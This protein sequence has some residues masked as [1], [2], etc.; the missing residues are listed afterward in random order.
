MNTSNTTNAKEFD[1]NKPN[2]TNKAEVEVYFGVFFDGT[3]NNKIQ[4]M[5]GKLYRRDE[6]LKSIIE[7]ANKGKIKDYNCLKF[8][9]NKGIISDDPTIYYRDQSGEYNLGEKKINSQ[10]DLDHLFIN[11]GYSPYW[12]DFT[13]STDGNILV[14]GIKRED[15]TS[16]TQNEIL[17]ESQLDLLY[18]GSDD[19]FIEDRMAEQLR[20]DGTAI[21]KGNAEEKKGDVDKTEHFS[22]TSTDKSKNMR[23][24]DDANELAGK[25]R[26]NSKYS[27]TNF[28]SSGQVG[29][30]T[31]VAILEAL[32]DASLTPTTKEKKTKYYSIYVEGSGA[33][34]RFSTA[35][36]AHVDLIGEGVL[37]LGKGT[38]PTGAVAKVRK[39]ARKVSTIVK[40]L[41]TE[42]ISL[43]IHFDIFGFSRGSAS[44]R[45][46]AYLV[47]PHNNN[48]CHLEKNYFYLTSPPHLSIPIPTLMDDYT[49]LGE[50]IWKKT[51]KHK[52][53]KKP[54]TITK[55]IR[56]L[57]IYDTVVSIGVYREPELISLS[58][59]GAVSVIASIADA[60]DLPFDAYRRVRPL[61]K[62]KVEGMEERVTSIFGKSHFHDQNVDDY[63]LHATDQAEEVFHICALDELRA[64]FALTDI[65]SS[66]DGGNG[67]ELFLPGCHTDIGGG[68]Y[69]RDSSK[70]ANIDKFQ[71][72]YNYICESNPYSIQKMKYRRVSVANFK[73]MGWLKDGDVAINN[74]DVI[75]PGTYGRF[76]QNK[77]YSYV[78]GGEDYYG[79]TV[80]RD[81]SKNILSRNNIIMNRYVKPGYSNLGLHLMQKRAN[82]EGEKRKMFN[83]IPPQYDVPSGGPTVIKEVA[84][85]LKRGKRYFVCPND[86]L[87]KELRKEY[88]HFSANEQILSPA[89]NIIVNPPN[90]ISANIKKGVTRDANEIIGDNIK[91]N[92]EVIK[93]P[94]NPIGR[95]LE[96]VKNVLTSSLTPLSVILKLLPQLRV[97]MEPD[98]RISTRIVYKGKKDLPLKDRVKMLYDYE[99][100]ES[101]EII[102]V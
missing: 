48:D 37:G 45:M 96:F 93:R 86:N 10:A 72:P 16:N 59:I 28:Y 41:K 88:L 20:N 40:G 71:G 3:N 75:T 77:G 65:Q 78:N 49:L 55:E 91:P 5:L 92:N 12:I 29:T 8:L 2:D 38:G 60:L 63:G 84:K 94:E 70:I 89:D 82:G 73:E 35:G 1:K 87:Y 46:F 26:K 42:A 99:P 25:S 6:I 43:N 47:D 14:R 76:T 23:I 56:F 19:S 53:K 32:Y 34:M 7:R 102:H 13:K 58:K 57:G 18:Y 51:F 79:D 85:E 80:Y 31:N 67:I 69:G 9:I 90:Y 50:K 97:Y 17:T 11:Y 30:Y 100:N 4:V 27:R 68:S 98:F 81:N 15:W 74:S 83:P 61:F 39:V 36:A 24:A 62:G 21:E 33:D 66:I 95:T 101:E 64:N 22:F 54:V 44:A 52:D